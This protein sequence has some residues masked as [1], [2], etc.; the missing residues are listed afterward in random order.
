MTTAGGSPAANSASARA[1]RAGHEYEP[2]RGRSAGARS[3]RSWCRSRARERRAVIES[4]AFH[5]CI[6]DTTRSRPALRVRNSGERWPSQSHTLTPHGRC[7]RARVP[8]P[9]P[10]QMAHGGLFPSRSPL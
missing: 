2:G 3:R 10:T 1:L 7:S 8:I 6:R 9:R 4:D 5:T